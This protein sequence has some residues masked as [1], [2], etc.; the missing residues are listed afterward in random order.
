MELA[1]AVPTYTKL[2]PIAK[3]NVIQALVSSILV[4]EVFSLYFFGLSELQAE[5]IKQLEEYL[6]KNGKN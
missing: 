6:S 2:L 1:D 5:K 4:R 3:F